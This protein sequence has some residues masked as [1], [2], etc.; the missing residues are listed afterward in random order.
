MWMLVVSMPIVK[1]S[2]HSSLV[3][4]YLA[5]HRFEAPRCVPAMWRLR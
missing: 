4:S 2:T 3:T 1:K 5:T